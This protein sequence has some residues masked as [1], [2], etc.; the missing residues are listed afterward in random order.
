MNWFNETGPRQLAL[1]GD[2]GQGKSTAAL[3]MTH[4]LLHASPG[5]RV[6]ILIDL[7]AASPMHLTPLQLL[8]AWSAQYGLDPRA[9]WALHLAGRLVIIFEGFDEMAL[10]GDAE[11]RIGHFKTLWA[12]CHPTAK[13]LITGR[14]NFFFD[15]E[16]M[17]AS[18]GLRE[19]HNDQP[20]CQAIRLQVFGLDQMKM[21]LRGYDAKVQEEMF[22]LAK[23]NKQFYEIVSRPSLLHIVAVLWHR[24]NLSEQAARITSAD[25]MRRF[26]RHSYTRQGL[27]EGNERQFMALTTEER[28]YFMRGVA[29]YMVA[30]RAPNQISGHD[31]NRAV[32][33]LGVCAAGDLRHETGCQ[34]KT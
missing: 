32:G 8:G 20:Y 27:K 14:P 19:P 30:K 1:L 2:Y 34:P 7:R 21:A 22:G 16:E 17:V 25:V 12:F 31:M 23:K 29:T 13:I 10:V 28:Q 11:M 18:L 4:E 15:R 5:G 9:L 33:E 26:V 24:E 6:P 3:A